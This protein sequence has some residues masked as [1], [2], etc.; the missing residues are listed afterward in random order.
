MADITAY[1]LYSG[2]SGNAT[3]IRTPDAEI[4]IDAGVSARAVEKNLNAI[5]TTLANITAI[6]VTHEHTDHTKGL[7]VISKKHH[8]PTHMV[9]ESARA[10]IRDPK[11][12]LLNDLYLHPSVFSVR[13][14]DTTVTSFPTPHDSAASVGYT[15]TYQDEKFGFATDIGHITDEI[16]EALSGSDAV[17]IES[18]HDVDMLLMGPYPYPLKRRV[19]SDTGH[20]SNASCA[21]FAAMLAETGTK[22]FVLAHLS[23]ENN[24]PPAANIVTREALSAFEDITLAVASLDIPTKVGEDQPMEIH[25][26]ADQYSLRR[27]H[28]G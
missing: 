28:Q 27:K 22:H 20:L 23:K 19:L 11:S 13:F 21:E 8:I 15:I 14:G 10:L 25:Y 7:E 24:Y 26:A 5:G 4:L 3:Y 9:N 6:F 2:S 16:T 1:V 18:N 12:S 17:V